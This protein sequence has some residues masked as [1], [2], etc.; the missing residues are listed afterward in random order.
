M[1]VYNGMQSVEIIYNLNFIA[2][3]FNEIESHYGN[4]EDKK[5]IYYTRVPRKYGESWS[6]RYEPDII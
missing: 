2:L 1:P 4:Q 3:I 5:I 6:R